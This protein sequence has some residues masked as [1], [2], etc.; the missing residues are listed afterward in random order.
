M[1]NGIKEA[2]GFGFKSLSRLYQ[3]YLEKAID[4]GETTPVQSHPRLRGCEK[5]PKS[6]EWTGGVGKIVGRLPFSGKTIRIIKIWKINRLRWFVTLTF[7]MSASY[8]LGDT[9]CPFCHLPIISHLLRGYT[10]SIILTHA[11]DAAGDR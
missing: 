8:N 9:P 1:D 4:G 2:K 11:E 7:S 6:R 3:N 10:G 5:I